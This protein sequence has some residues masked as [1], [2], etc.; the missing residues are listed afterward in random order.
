MKKK[1]QIFSYMFYIFF[2]MWGHLTR[3]SRILQPAF[4]NI[5]QSTS[6]FSVF[7]NS[8][9]INNV[10][11]INQVQSNI[12]QPVSIGINIQRGMKQVGRVKRRCKDCYMVW[13][14]ERLYNMCKTHPRHKQMSIIP[15]PRSSWILTHA[16]QSV[17]RAW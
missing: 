1:L 15:K 16:S 5:L 12:L 8:S 13:R 7:S 9:I 17:Y 3:V 2:R 14:K 6:R 10:T 4:F 11:T